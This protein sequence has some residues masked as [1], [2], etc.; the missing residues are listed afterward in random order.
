MKEFASAF[1]QAQAEIIAALKG[2]DN[3]A[4]KSKYA[5]FGAVV[6]AIKPACT[7]HGL[8]YIQKI[9]ERE[10]GIYCETVILH[11][12]GESFSTDKLPMPAPKDNPH[13]YGSAITYAKRYSL[14]AAFGVPSEDDDGNK[15]VEGAKAHEELKRESAPEGYEEWKMNMVTVAD[16]GLERLQD[17]WK[18]SSAA[19]RNFAVK[20]DLEWWNGCKHRASP[21][22]T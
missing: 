5:D 21:K 12:S 19:L 1:V 10:G 13:G 11:K 6:D 18:S 20:Y 14:Q 22:S 15:A 3:P 4:F 17:T 9:T 7:K 8:G 16:E 2:S